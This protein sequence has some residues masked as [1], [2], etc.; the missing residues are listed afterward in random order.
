[1]MFVVLLQFLNPGFPGVAFLFFFFFKGGA[2]LKHLWR[3]F[4]FFL[5]S[6]AQIQISGSK[7]PW[8]LHQKHDFFTVL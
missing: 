6:G 7:H 3:L 8:F 2:L 5:A 4:Y 1:M